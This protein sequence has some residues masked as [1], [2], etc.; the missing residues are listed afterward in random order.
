MPV[1][2]YMRQI[3]ASARRTSYLRRNAARGQALTRGLSSSGGRFSQR[4]RKIGRLDERKLK[5][6]GRGCAHENT[7]KN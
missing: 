4:S 7:E 6:K 5:I 1:N 3:A 2:E